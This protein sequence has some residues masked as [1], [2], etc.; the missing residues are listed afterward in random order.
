[1][2]FSQFMPTMQFGLLSSLMM[3]WALMGDILLLPATV[4]AI[5]TKIGIKPS[6]PAQCSL[7]PREKI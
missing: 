1:M 6:K 7:S 4:M 2:M 5:S 3:L